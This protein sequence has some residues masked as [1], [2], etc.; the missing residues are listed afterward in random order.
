M[1]TTR[2]GMSYAEIGH[3]VAQRVTDAIE[4]IAIYMKQIHMARDS[5]NQVVRQGTT[6]AKN[7]NNK[8]KWKDLMHAELG[9]FDVIISMDWLSKYHAVIVCDG[10]IV[11]IPCENEVLTIQGHRSNVPGAALVARSPYRLAP[12]EMQELSTQLQ[13]LSDKG[14]IRPYSSPWGALNRYPLPRID[15]LFDQLQGS[16]VYSKIDLR[17]G[18]HQLRVREEDIPEL[19]FRTRYG[20]YK[21]QVIPLGLTN[22]LAVFMDLMNW[23]CKPYLD[24]FLTVFIDDRLICSK[25]KEEHEEYLKLILELLKKE[26]YAKFSK[27]E[28]WLSKV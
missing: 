20:R 21:F 2:Q 22:A 12:S 13:E 4:A 3:I 10:E 19:T 9:S 14:F 8:R 28:F 11:R 16:G 5:M 18:Y 27:C 1:S 24:K 23:V 26:V 25:S 17:S 15:D 7:A 6:V